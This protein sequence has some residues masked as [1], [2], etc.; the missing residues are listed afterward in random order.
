MAGWRGQ[1]IAFVEGSF[2][3]ERGSGILP[4]WELMER[5]PSFRWVGDQML[6]AALLAALA[7][8]LGWAGRGLTRPRAQTGRPHTPRRSGAL[9]AASR[10]TGRVARPARTIPALAL[11]PRPRGPARGSGRAG[12]SRIRRWRFGSRRK[13]WLT[14]FR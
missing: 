11:A 8:R 1:H 10:A 9:L 13:G 4:L 5:L 3:L 6:V 7:R 14:P 12:P 2:V